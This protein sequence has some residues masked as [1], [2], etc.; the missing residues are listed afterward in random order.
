[1]S[2]NDRGH[3]VGVGE[4]GV[5]EVFLNSTEDRNLKKHEGNYARIEKKVVR[6][7][8]HVKSGIKTE[9]EMQTNAKGSEIP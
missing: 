3:T 6:F 1:L 9:K 2:K 7:H 4:L 5:Q 8:P